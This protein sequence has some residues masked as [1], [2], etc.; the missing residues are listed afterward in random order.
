MEIRRRN[1]IFD[2]AL[3]IVKFKWQWAGHIAYRTF[4]RYGI[5]VFE[6]RPQT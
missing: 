4:N 2:I 1:N 6:W 5:K 3:K